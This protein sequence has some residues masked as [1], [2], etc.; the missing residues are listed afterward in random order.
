[1]RLIWKLREHRAMMTRPAA[2]ASRVSEARK[3][4]GDGLAIAD[5]L[6]KNVPQVVYWGTFV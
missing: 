6:A 1:L 5:R 4:S 3:S 2:I